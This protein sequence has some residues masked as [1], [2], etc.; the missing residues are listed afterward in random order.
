MSCYASLGV[1]RRKIHNFYVRRE[2]PTTKALYEEL[3][4]D[5]PDLPHFKLS[6]LRNWMKNLNFSYVKLKRKPVWMESSAIAAQRDNFLRNIKFYRDNGYNIF[7]T[8]ETWCGANH[9]RKYGWVEN[10]DSSENSN[11]DYYRNNVQEVF[12]QRGGFIT[13]S[14]SG[15]RVIILHIGGKNGFVAGC[16]KCFI[17]KKGTDDY[18]G[19]MNAKHYEEWFRHVLTVL[20]PKSVIVIDQAPY[21]TML[22]PEF[23]NPTAEWLKA[24]IIEWLIKR[25]VPVPDFAEDFNDLTKQSLLE[26]SRSYRYPKQY[27]LEKITTEIRGSEIKLLWLPVA[28]CE[29]NAIELIWAFAKNY[30]AKHNKVHKVQNVHKLC[31]EALDHVTPLLW[32]NCVRHAEAEEEKSRKTD[33]CVEAQIESLI[34]NTADDSDDDDQESLSLNNSEEEL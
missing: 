6:T 21:H 5:V 30:V 19:E 12:G 31:L 34:I 2:F 10:L 32:S 3:I 8:D 1:I 4:N 11:F 15:L 16:S 7:Y 33:Q 27:L 17:G 9:T 22:D 20:P 29:F 26:L 14:G 13:P 18:H 25:G 28:H 23:R 24:R